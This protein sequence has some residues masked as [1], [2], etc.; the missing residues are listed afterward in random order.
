MNPIHTLQSDTGAVSRPTPWYRNP[1]F[2][3]PAVIGVLI[4]AVASAAWRLYQENRSD[5]TA[6]QEETATSTPATPVSVQ[7]VG[8][9][10]N[11]QDRVIAAGTIQ[12]EAAVRITARTNG[13]LAYLGVSEGTTIR[14]GELIAQI[15]NPMLTANL[16]S[17][18]TALTNALQSLAVTEGVLDQSVRQAESGVT[19]AEA[20]VQSASVAITSAEV[21]LENA[22]AAQEQA[23]LEQQQNAG[24]A[25]YSYLY[26]M[27]NALDQVDYIL[28]S[29]GGGPQLAGIRNVLGLK[30][31]NALTDARNTYIQIQQTY[32]ELANPINERQTAQIRLTRMG[33]GLDETVDLISKMLDVLDATLTSPEFS[34]AQ[35]SAQQS[36][37]LNLRSS[38]LGTSREV[39]GTVTAL[40]T[41]PINQKR[42]LDSLRST[43]AAAKK[44]REIA[45][46]GVAN[47][48]AALAGTQKSRDQQ[49]IAAANAVASARAQVGV[50]EAQL[51][52]LTITAPISGTVVEVGLEEGEEIGAGT[53]IARIATTNLVTINVALPPADIARIKVG[54][55]AFIPLQTPAEGATTDPV[56]TATVSRI[57]AV[58][59]EQSKKVT[60]EIAYDN[61]DGA[62]IPGTFV[63][64]QIPLEPR[65]DTVGTF[66]VPLKAVTIGQTE[67]Y[68]FVVVDGVARR[69]D[70]TL[71][72]TRGETIAV[73]SGLNKDDVL[74]TDGARNV[75]EGE[76]VTVQ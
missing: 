73:T 76:E 48:R 75:A 66:F 43:V 59:D 69:R 65:A 42:E 39:K 20:Q 58:A 60:V 70:V 67:Q 23:S 56:L 57:D 40:T 2:I 8:E 12:A 4:I 18:Q 62:L 52:D 17:A 21:N 9:A 61:R 63:E 30:D 36:A 55:E 6:G 33:E 26:V 5:S 25:Y 24:N 38:V 54:Q 53:F 15:N 19:S 74:I 46:T 72:E 3:I 51:N 1:R 13:M 71:G 7:I 32:A 31:L 10:G 50:V 14:A 29:D 22:R 11:G 34:A 44:Q 28:D 64:V 27:K 47:A 45:E 49:R 35:L 41:L 37:F 16:T 68:V